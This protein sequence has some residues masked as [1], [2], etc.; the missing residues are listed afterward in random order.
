MT[1]MA[2]M[3]KT[4]QAPSDAEKEEIVAATERHR[5]RP[6]RVAINLRQENGTATISPTHSDGL[7]WEARLKDALGTTSPAFLDT[8]LLRLVNFFGDR[9]RG[10]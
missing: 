7:G 10:P 5:E 9:A 1:G 6:P 4:D 3:T 8:E 2:N